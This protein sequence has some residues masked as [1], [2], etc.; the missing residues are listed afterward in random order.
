MLPYPQDHESL[1]IW[2]MTIALVYFV[3]AIFV[4]AMRKRTKDFS[5]WM[6]SIFD[7]VLFASSAILLWGVFDKN[8]LVQFNE[9]T[10][11][12]LIAGMGGCAWGLYS[13]VH[14]K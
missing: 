9:L 14:D 10:A 11:F 2:M 8:V 13:L 12:L 6:K 4:L 1:S 3:A 7:G 5:Y